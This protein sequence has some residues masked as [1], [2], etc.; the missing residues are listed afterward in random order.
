MAAEAFTTFLVSGT[1][2]SSC[3]GPTIMVMES[4][5]GCWRHTWS[6][7]TAFYDTL[8]KSAV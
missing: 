5:N 4:S 6:A 7:T 1:E 3:M 2:A 8:V